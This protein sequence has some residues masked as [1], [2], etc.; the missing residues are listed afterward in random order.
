[1]NP[2]NPLVPKVT[3]SEVGGDNMVTVTIDMI[4]LSATYDIP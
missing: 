1:M 4:P 2:N 3:L